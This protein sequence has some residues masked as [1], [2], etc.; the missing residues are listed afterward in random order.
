MAKVFCK[1][2]FDFVRKTTMEK[3]KKNSQK[4]PEHG[5]KYV[6]LA[7]CIAIS[8]LR[9]KYCNK[10]EENEQGKLNKLPIT[11]YAKVKNKEQKQWQPHASHDSYTFQGFK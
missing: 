3:L 9:Q 11:D 6:F 7:K 5:K 8:V 2:R 10:N 1:Q 4:K